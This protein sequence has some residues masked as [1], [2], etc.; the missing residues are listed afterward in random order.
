MV[1]TEIC[2]LLR[3]DVHNITEHD[4]ILWYNYIV[5]ISFINLDQV[6]DEFDSESM[7]RGRIVSF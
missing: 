5:N 7:E 4:V 6:I 1:T 2:I 3:Q